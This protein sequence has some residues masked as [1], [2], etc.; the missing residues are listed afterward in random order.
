MRMPEPL[1][2][3][4]VLESDPTSSPKCARTRKALRACCP[5]RRRCC[6]PSLPAISSVC[7]RT[8]VWDGSPRDCSTLSSSS[9][10][11]TA[12][13]ARPMERPSRL[14]FTPAIGR[15]GCWSPKLRAN[16]A[17]CVQCRS[18]AH[19]RIPA[20]AARRALR[21]CSTRCPIATTRRWCCAGSCARCRS[22]A[23]YSASPHATRACPR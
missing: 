23:A 21:A 19:A 7:R 17:A 11:R 3:R 1:P 13:C 12:A 14:A 15:S 5:S 6:S 22:A 10:A 2:L 20:T 16:C 9:S 18:P 4:D 8:Q